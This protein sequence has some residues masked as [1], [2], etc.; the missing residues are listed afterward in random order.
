MCL[1]PP[2]KVTIAGFLGHYFGMTKMD[3]IDF[4]FVR[5]KCHT[6]IAFIIYHSDA[7]IYKHNLQGTNISKTQKGKFEDDFTFTTDGKTLNILV[8]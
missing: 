8:L 5:A 3:W 2:Q 4:R 1:D 6:F 7:Y